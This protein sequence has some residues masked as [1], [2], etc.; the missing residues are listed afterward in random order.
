MIA[1]AA[2]WSFSGAIAAQ[3]TGTREASSF[4][5]SGSYLAARQA[6]L[7]RDPEAAATYYRAALKSD[8][9]NTELL[10]QTFYSELASGGINEAVRLPQRVLQVR[11]K[12]PKARHVLSVRA[13]QQ[14]PRKDPPRPFQRPITAT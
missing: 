2:L 7:D 13:V 3:V 14:K 4:T 12:K 11:S 9:R 5:P 6:N 1:T 8:Q 10:E